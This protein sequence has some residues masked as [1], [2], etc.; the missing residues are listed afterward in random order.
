MK[1]INC[2]IVEDDSAFQKVAYN[3]VEKADR[4]LNP[5][6]I[7]STGKEAQEM[8]GRY[9]IDIIF[10]DVHMPDMTG[11]EFLDEIEIPDDVQII[12]MT[13]D[14][15]FALKAFEYGITDYLLKP[16]SQIRFRKAIT[17]A[18]DNLRKD[19]NSSSTENVLMKKALQM[20]HSRRKPII[21]LPNR[22]S[23]LG[24]I[25]PF[26]TV[27]LDYDNEHLAVDILESAEKEGL[28]KGEF[29]DYIYSCNSC[30]NSLLHF[31][32][33]CPKCQSTDLDI[34][35]LLHHFPCAYVGPVSDFMK[36]ESGDIMECPKCSRILK[37]IGVDYDKPSVMYTCNKCD[38]EFQDPLIKA[39]CHDC[40]ADNKVDRLLKKKVKNYHLTKLGEDAATG[41]LPVNLKGFDELN[42]IINEDYFLRLLSNEIGRKAIADFEST[43]AAVQFSNLTDL[44]Q[45]IGEEGQKNLI[46]ELFDL[47]N[48]DIRSSDGII[49]S[50]RITMLLLFT[51]ADQDKSRGV[52]NRVTSHIKNLIRDNFDGFEV[53]INE[54]MTSV[55][56]GKSAE[57]QL[58]TLLMPFEENSEYE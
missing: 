49:F 55:E 48:Q 39:K 10:L 27:N 50:D 14:Q 42:E 30:Y 9:D 7:A 23:K 37:H 21:A 19:V 26:L 43:I 47:V 22:N 20:S 58:Q 57:I 40:G 46:E 44:F 16:F 54:N 11:F 6:G 38:N 29:V 15:E 5:V 35:D 18:I 28:I 51:E 2:L 52:L 56:E 25:Y 12:L 31:R 3:M 1:K 45:G 33:S 34:E 13:G 8:F 24:Y 32:E 36:S 17:R 53:E 4:R 41:K